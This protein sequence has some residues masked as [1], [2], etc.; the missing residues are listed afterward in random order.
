[1]TGA[2]APPE[3]VME[4]LLPHKKHFSMFRSFSLA[5]LITFGNLACGLAAISE[6]Q[7]AMVSPSARHL[8][9]AIAF[10][11]GALLCDIVDGMVA[12]WRNTHSTFGRELDT[13]SDVISFGVAP[14]ALCYA[15]GY[16]GGWDRA[17]LTFFLICGVARLARFNVTSEAL[18]FGGSKVR[19][20]EGVPIPTTVFLMVGLGVLAWL[21]KLEAWVNLGAAPIGPWMLHPTVLILGLLGPLMVS[22]TIRIH[23]P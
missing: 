15:A 16:R 10:L 7:A 8:I 12:R 2:G 22:T 23:K 19:Y 6:A 5:D 14:V 4:D 20:T 11:P 9:L 17:V 18:S 1:V 21:G 13:L 3:F